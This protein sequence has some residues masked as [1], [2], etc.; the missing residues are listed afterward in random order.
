MLSPPRTPTL[1]GRGGGNGAGADAD[2]SRERKLP[3]ALNF[4]VWFI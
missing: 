4:L 1:G 3:A 2:P